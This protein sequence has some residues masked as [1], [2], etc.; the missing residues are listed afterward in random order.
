ME[1]SELRVIHKTEKAQLTST[2]LNTQNLHINIKYD[3]QYTLNL[4]ASIMGDFTTGL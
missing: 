2:F 1:L 4:T 3:S